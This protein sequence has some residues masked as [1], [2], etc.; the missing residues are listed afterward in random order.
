LTSH[1]IQLNEQRAVLEGMIL[2]PNMV[3]PGL[4]CPPSKEVNEV[5]VGEQ[6]Y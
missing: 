6:Q 1:F 3:L 4:A 2:R 5:G